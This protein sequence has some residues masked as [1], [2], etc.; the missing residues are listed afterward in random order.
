MLKNIL[1]TKYQK[2]YWEISTDFPAIVTPPVTSSKSMSCHRLQKSGLL[3]ICKMLEQRKCYKKM[4]IT[5][6]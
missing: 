2:Y 3:R 6:A 1:S 5:K 4:D